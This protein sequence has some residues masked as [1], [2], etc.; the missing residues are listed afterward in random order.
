MIKGVKICGVSDP[1]TLSYII[2]HPYPPD[3]IGFIS[4][5]KKVKDMLILKD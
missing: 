4:N 2:N 3:Y 1:E 5:F